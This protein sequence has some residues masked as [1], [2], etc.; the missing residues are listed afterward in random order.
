VITNYDISIII[1][2]LNEADTLNYLV[3][4]L[5]NYLADL[6]ELRIEVLFV[7]DGSTDNSVQ[8]LKQL[9]HSHYHARLI[10]LS[11]NFGSHAAL[12]AGILSSQGNH[13]TFLSAD[14]QDPPELVLR[15]YQKCQEGNDVALA[16]RNTAEARLTEKIFSRLY[17]KL[18][19]RFVAK[20]FPDKGFDIAMFNQKVKGELDQAMEAHSSLFLQILTLGFKQ[21]TICYDKR[22]RSTG[23][24][25][26]TFTKKVKLILL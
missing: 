26:W 4:E 13:I 5:N 12:R 6:T 20:D 2:F 10:K 22:K 19:Q 7:D 11:K 21:G 8:I 18:I 25:K 3:T 24:S 9:E 14:L 15:L 17:A 1:P 23:K 16:I